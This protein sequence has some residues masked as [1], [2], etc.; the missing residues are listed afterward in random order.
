MKLV[1][2][3][4][5]GGNKYSYN[6]LKEYLA[7]SNI[8]MQ[9]IE[10]P[11]HGQRTSEGLLSSID[12]IVEDAF[13]ELVYNIDDHYIIYGHSMGALVGY[14]LCKKIKSFD[15]IPPLKLIVSGKASP[16]TKRKIKTYH[17]PSQLFW[18]RIKNLGG[19]PCEL[20]YDNSLVEFFEP[21]LRSDFK[22]VEDYVHSGHAELSIPI[23]VFYGDKELK[24]EID[25]YKWQYETSNLTRIFKLK[26]N[27]F[28][29]YNHKKKIANNIIQGFK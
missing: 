12:E 6:F 22:I 17:L 10:Y 13:H 7:F 26:G 19:I 21:I 27:H 5:A 9:V 15:I 25:I 18:R 4:F 3:P 23:D 28:F 2:F 16:S 1:A 20:L 29:I 14:L 8:D 11:G 24:V